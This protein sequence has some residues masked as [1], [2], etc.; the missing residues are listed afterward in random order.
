MCN[1]EKNTTIHEFAIRLRNGDAEATAFA[2]AACIAIVTD[3]QYASE[4]PRSIITSACFRAGD[5]PLREYLHGHGHELRLVELAL[6]NLRADARAWQRMEPP[7]FAP[8][9]SCIWE[10]KLYG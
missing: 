3:E 1:R 10:Q 2:D 6:R 4:A 7:Y 8:D 5:R 9:G